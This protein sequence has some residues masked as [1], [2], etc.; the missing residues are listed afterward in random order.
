MIKKHMSI[1]TPSFIMKLVP[2]E[3][4]VLSFNFLYLGLFSFAQVIAPQ[5][6]VDPQL[7]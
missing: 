5:V 2:S 6:I 1:I 4:L 7:T 3:Q